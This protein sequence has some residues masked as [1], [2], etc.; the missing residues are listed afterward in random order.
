MKI[1]T[2]KII[3]CTLILSMMICLLTFTVPVFAAPDHL[4]IYQEFS[5]IS[6]NR[7]KTQDNYV[8]AIHF[9]INNF[10]EEEKKYEIQFELFDSTGHNSEIFNLSSFNLSLGEY[11]EINFQVESSLKYDSISLF[12]IKDN[13]RIKQ[14][15]FQIQKFDTNHSI[16][17]SLYILAGLLFISSII[18]VLYKNKI[19]KNFQKVVFT[20][21]TLS[22]L[23]VSIIIGILENTYNS[24]L[25]ALSTFV[26]PSIFEIFDTKSY[27]VCRKKTPKIMHDKLTGENHNQKI[28]LEFESK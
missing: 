17:L 24:T 8:Y 2:L 12:S 16:K 3:K 26:I 28:E 23:A 9:K 10:L 13:V 20:I 1:I 19:K 27:I 5:N 21:I 6:F 22:Y 25:L 11:K 4:L 7:E 18:C 14:S 15:S